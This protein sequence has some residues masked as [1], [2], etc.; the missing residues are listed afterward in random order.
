MT[1]W[2]YTFSPPYAFMTF[3]GRI[4]VWQPLT[5]VL[6]YQHTTDCRVNSQ[7]NPRGICGGRMNTEAEFSASTFSTFA[8]YASF[9]WSWHLQQTDVSLQ[10]QNGLVSLRCKW[11]INYPPP[12]TQFTCHLVPPLRVHLTVYWVGTSWMSWVRIPSQIYLSPPPSTYRTGFHP[13]T[14]VMSIDELLP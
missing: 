2:R 9:V 1:E 7:S 3:T 8:P 11:K 14:Y 5:L 6:S 13:T 4:N 10:C 12:I